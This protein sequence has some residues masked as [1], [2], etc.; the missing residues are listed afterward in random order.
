MSRLLSKISFIVP[1][2]EIGKLSFESYKRNV[3][4]VC[5]SGFFLTTFAKKKSPGPKKPR[6][7]TLGIFWVKYLTIISELEIK[8][9]PE[10]R[11]PGLLRQSLKLREFAISIA[12]MLFFKP[13]NFL[14]VHRWDHSS[15]TK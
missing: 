3:F 12:K 9:Y 7:Q 2:S 13:Q 6:R 15:R 10:S 5:I 11:V 1:W 4:S 14:G 8:V